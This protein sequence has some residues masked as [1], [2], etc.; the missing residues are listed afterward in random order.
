MKCPVCRED[1]LHATKLDLDIPGYRCERCTGTWISSNEYLAW[2][3][4]T[5]SR[6]PDKPGDGAELPT[7]DTQDLKLCPD[8]GHILTRYQVLPNAQFN[9]DRCGH[10][11]GV[12][13]DH[14]EWEVVAARNL[15]DKVNLFFTQP[16][17]ARVHDEQT[18]MVLDKL[19][20]EKFGADDYAKIQAFRQWLIAHPRRAMLMAF[21]QAENP[22][23]I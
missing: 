14:G 18:R 21:L 10:C 3:K 20:Q 19:Y 15:H 7:W 11:N 8:C 6:L 22:Y 17:Q 9:L 12:W 2:F 23:K 13:F 4:A 1:T 5:G 16:W